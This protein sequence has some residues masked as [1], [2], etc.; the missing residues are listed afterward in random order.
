MQLFRQ[1]YALRD[2]LDAQTAQRLQDHLQLL[3]AAP[4]TRQAAPKKPLDSATAKQQL[5]IKQLH[6]EVIRQQ[7][8][9]RKITEKDPKQALEILDKARQMV[10]AAGVDSDAKGQM[11]RLIGMSKDDV[12][13]YIVA[14]K[15]AVGTERREQGSADARSSGAIVPG[16]RS[17][18]SWP[19]W[20]TIS[21]N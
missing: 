2:Q 16:S 14:N 3:S 13:K 10:E 8:A 21:I 9:A 5:A 7:E 1:A 20:S 4:G 11:L 17:T 12:D 19:S 15:A 6:H 18:P